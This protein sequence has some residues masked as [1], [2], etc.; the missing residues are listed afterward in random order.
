MRIWMRAELSRNIILTKRSF[1]DAYFHPE[2]RWQ[3]IKLSLW[4]CHAKN[5]EHRLLTQI[6]Y[7]SA[8][9][10]KLGN[11]INKKKTCKVRLS[12][13]V[14]FIKSIILQFGDYLP[15]VPPLP[16]KENKPSEERRRRIWPNMLISFTTWI[17]FLT[18]NFDSKIN[19]LLI[20]QVMNLIIIQNQFRETFVQE[21][22]EMLKNVFHFVTKHAWLN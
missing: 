21:M 14:G 8:C 19:W 6:H 2:E 13:L 22:S 7:S 16:L 12:S 4:T 18:I 3:F 10:Q 17:L 5:Q 11:I 1:K 9:L 15:K 20:N